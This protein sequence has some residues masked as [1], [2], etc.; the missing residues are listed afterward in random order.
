M[1]GRRVST[2]SVAPTRT[3]RDRRNSTSGWRFR[4]ALALL[5]TSSAVVVT[6][7]AS[8]TS[9]DGPQSSL[10]PFGAVCA[11]SVWLAWLVARRPALFV[12]AMVTVSTLF[13]SGASAMSSGELRGIGFVFGLLANLAIGAGAL[14]HRVV[15]KAH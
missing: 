2:D 4:C 11:G 13:W 5:L 6:A 15:S 10:I 12:A 8:A 9:D 7:L 14:V 1:Y 3:S